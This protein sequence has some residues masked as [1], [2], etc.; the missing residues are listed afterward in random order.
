MR[1]QA[2]HLVIG[3]VLAVLAGCTPPPAPAPPPPLP[4]PPLS[5]EDLRPI[6]RPRI[7]ITDLNESPSSDKKVV[8]VSGR[9]VN[10]GSGTTREVYVHVE[11][12]NRDGA[13]VQ[14]AD[15]E[16]TTELIAPGSTADFAV[17][18]ENRGDVDR[19]HVEAVS[20]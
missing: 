12:L 6:E 9:L 13:V 20:R 18:L 15:S 16:P 1:V 19:Y 8:S 4:T 7:V 14:S 11:A 2:G 17:T 5:E 10:R 3:L